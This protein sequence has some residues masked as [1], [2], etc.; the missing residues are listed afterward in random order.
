MQ[1]T[2]KDECSR[3]A[4]AQINAI[5]EAPAENVGP[6][7]YQTWFKNSTTLTIA[8][9]R[10]KVGALNL[11]TASWIKDHLLN[12]ISL[13]VRAVTLCLLKKLGTA[14]LGP[15]ILRNYLKTVTLSE[16]KGLAGINKRFFAEFTLERSEGIRMTSCVLR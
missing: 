3:A 7:K 9:G 14:R 4:A 15:S 2:I 8:D 11:F 5:D 10:L 16:A 12:E 13:S 1:C 6:P